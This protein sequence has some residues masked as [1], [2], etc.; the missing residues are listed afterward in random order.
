VPR[1]EQWTPHSDR[2]RIE[3]VIHDDT[4]I[5]TPSGVLDLATYA[6][7][8]ATL[9]KYALETPQA[10]IVDID[11]LRLPMDAAL[12]VFTSV[13]MEVSEWPAVPVLLVTTDTMKAEQ[14]RRNGISRFVAVHSSIHDATARL[15]RPWP[16]RRAVF[17]IVHCSASGTVTRRRVEQA[18]INWSCAD[19]VVSDAV[20]IATA[21]VENSMRHT[22]GDARVRL[23][24]VCGNLT[25]AV[26]DGIPDHDHP[27]GTR[28]TTEDGPGLALVDNLAYVRGNARTLTGGNVVWAILKAG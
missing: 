4:M 28:L 25:I 7:L 16:R 26:Y 18:C 8:R 17:D 15:T 21:L 10:M 19:H 24:L 1:T 2:L 23:E 5:V 6:Q 3:R 27:N 9:L 20:T 13:W 22:S 14:L 12:V 11:Q